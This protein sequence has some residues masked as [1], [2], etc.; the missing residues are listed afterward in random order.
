MP[1]VTPQEQRR[2][3]LASDYEDMVAIKSRFLNWQASKGALPYFERY[4][5][6]VRVRTIVAPNQFA[7]E[8]HIIITLPDEYPAVAPRVCIDTARSRIPYHPNWY[9]SGLFCF[10]TWFPA[11]RLGEHVVRVVRT[12]Q[13]DP[14]VTKPASA[15]N[16]GAAEWWRAMENRGLFPSDKQDVRRRF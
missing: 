13:F 9:A 15:A 16:S 3:R 12:L 2:L 6:T 8:T 1:S 4:D 14:K 10:G 7:D 5:V 11:E